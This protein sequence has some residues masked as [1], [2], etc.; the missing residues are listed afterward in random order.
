MFIG[1]RENGRFRPRATAFRVVY[2]QG[3]LKFGHLVTAEHVVSG[4]QSKGHEIWVRANLPGDQETAEFPIDPSL[5]YFHPDDEHPTDVAV[6]PMGG[7]LLDADGRRVQLDHLPLAVNG[8]HDVSA[9]DAVCKERG[10]GV[11]DEIAIVGLF[12]SHYGLQRNVPVFRRGNIAAMRGEPIH[13]SYSG[14]ID[15]YLVEAMSIGGLSGSPVLVSM[16]GQRVI[17]GVTEDPRGKHGFYLL[18]LMHGHFDVASLN[19]DVVVEDER[20]STS[21]IHTGMGVVV[22]VQKIIETLEGPDLVQFRKQQI[23]KS[24]E[25]GA[26]PDIDTIVSVSPPAAGKG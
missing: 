5:F 2:E 26:T 18:G 13:T 24:R 15:A 12:R 10:I 22:P 7:H 16:F 3:G 11:G 6:L 8:P 9:S 1:T 17:E 20:D 25:S 23:D 14:Y 21:G 19:E 4:L